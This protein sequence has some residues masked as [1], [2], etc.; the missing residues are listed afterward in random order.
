MSGKNFYR[1]KGTNDICNFELADDSVQK[2]LEKRFHIF[3]A[4]DL[5]KNYCNTVWYYNNG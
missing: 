5:G 3:F 2:Q 4:L 1:H